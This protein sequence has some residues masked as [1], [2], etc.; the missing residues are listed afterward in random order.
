ML[1]E[2]LKEIACIF[3]MTFIILTRIEP[4]SLTLHILLTV[5]Y[6]VLSLFFSIKAYRTNSNV[7]AEQKKSLQWIHNCLCCSYI[8]ILI[9]LLL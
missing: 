4:A 9:L 6:T 2:V 1:K 3:G 7:P 5:T 8:T